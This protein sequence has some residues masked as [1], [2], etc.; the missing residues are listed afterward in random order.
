MLFPFALAFYIPPRHLRITSTLHEPKRSETGIPLLRCTKN[1]SSRCV[2]L[3]LRLSEYFPR[4]E[5]F[6]SFFPFSRRV[7]VDRIPR[8][9]FS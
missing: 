1:K 9:T 8:F 4:L 2:L 3:S 6:S 7:C 5:I